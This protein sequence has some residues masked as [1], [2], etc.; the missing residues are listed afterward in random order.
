V[1]KLTF[2]LIVATILGCNG[3]PETT[4]L[5][6]NQKSIPKAKELSKVEGVSLKRLEDSSRS[7]IM[8]PE[9]GDFQARNTLFEIIAYVASDAQIL[10]EAT[11]PDDHF[12]LEILP[13]PSP[14]DREN[15][16]KSKIAEVCRKNFGIKFESVKRDR[17][18][19][20]VSQ[21]DS[22][23]TNLNP[24]TPGNTAGWGTAGSGYEFR[25]QSFEQL[26]TFLGNELGDFVLDETEDNKSYCFE[27]PV[28]IFATQDDKSWN[29]ALK[30]IGLQLRQANRSV[31]FTLIENIKAP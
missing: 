29:S 15:H 7:S 6:K 3:Q 19:F 16:I 9:D 8:M 25:N 22:G 12:L 31:R 30:S 1:A 23:L 27:L 2:V 11:L 10:N 21:L 28:D 13:A 24:E 26:A 4:D 14:E 17:N 20:V 5:P 18:V